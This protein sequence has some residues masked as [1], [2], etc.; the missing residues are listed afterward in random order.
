MT[1]PTPNDPLLL[2]HEYDGIQEYDNPLP[3]WWVWLFWITIVYSILYVLNVPGIGMGA[4]R[5]A[6]YEADVEAANA[7]RGSGEA[8]ASGAT[9]S[10][11]TVMSGRPDLV[12]AGATI[13]GTR[14]AVCHGADGGGIIGPN[15]TDAFWLH[16]A[17]PSEIHRTISAGVLTKGM[18]AWDRVLT[19]DEVT[20]VTTYVMSLG[21]TTP[22]A[23]KPPEGERHEPSVE[24]EV[25]PR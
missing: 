21:G 12:A 13:Y 10:A 23:P 8:V 1:D 16:G 19:P 3:R 6:V 24:P 11:L 9:D 5:V 2:D 17:A 22:A 20:Q 7:I 14:C 25:P 18:P 15:L 4:G